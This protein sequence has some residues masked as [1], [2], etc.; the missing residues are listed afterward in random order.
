MS[1]ICGLLKIIAGEGHLSVQGVK[2]GLALPRVG[3]CLAKIAQTHAN[4][5][6]GGPYRISFLQLVPET[7]S[8]QILH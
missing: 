7:A 8:L 3:S 5:V 2:G 4:M 1:T 6:A